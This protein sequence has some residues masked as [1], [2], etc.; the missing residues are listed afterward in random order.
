MNMDI[1]ISQASKILGVSRPTV[2]AMIERGDLPD[3]ITAI[4]IMLYMQKLEREAA[5]I[6]Q[7]LGEFLAKSVQAA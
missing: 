4:D 3:P 7:R 6:K 5:G 2:Y 1:N